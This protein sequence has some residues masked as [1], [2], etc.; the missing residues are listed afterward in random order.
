MKIA[1]VVILYHPDEN[2]VENILSY[3]SFVTQVYIAD[4]TETPFT[5]IIDS[6]KRII[7]GCIY[8]HDGNND[9][10]AARLNEICRRAKADG[11]DFILTMDQDSA[12]DQNVITNYFRCFDHF[13]GKEQV[14]MFGVQYENPHWSSELCNP[15]PWTTLITSGSLVNLALFDQTG[16]FD[17]NLFIDTVD[18]EYCFRSI[19]K[20]FKIILFKNILLTHLLGTRKNPTRTGADRTVSYSLHSPIRLYYMI[21]NHM[22]LRRIYKNSF[23]GEMSRS[24]KAVL[25][26]LKINLLHNTDKLSIMR[27]VLQGI[28]DFKRQRMGK[29]RKK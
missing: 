28:V 15:V 18:F 25:N 12:F 4:N 5:K 27:F 1:A 20:G 22:Y 29:Y 6:L 3:S 16:G 14:A 10:I 8:I 21:R 9:G 2:T 17:E 23:P 26:R 7:P 11:F 24:G 13:A 19:R